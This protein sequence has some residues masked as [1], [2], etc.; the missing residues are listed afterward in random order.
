MLN[1]EYTVVTQ[2]LIDE[3]NHL[4]KQRTAPTVARNSP[5]IRLYVKHDGGLG[6]EVFYN[7]FYRLGD[8]FERQYQ[9]HM[10]A[11]NT[12]QT[13]HPVNMAI[14]ETRIL[15]RQYQHASGTPQNNL[16]HDVYEHFIRLFG[17]QVYSGESTLNHYRADDDDDRGIHTALINEI[18]PFQWCTF[19]AAGESAQE[20]KAQNPLC[21]F[22]REWRDFVSTLWRSFQLIDFSPIEPND[23]AS[24]IKNILCNQAYTNDEKLQAIKVL[25]NLTENDTVSD[26]ANCFKSAYWRLVYLEDVSLREEHF[27]NIVDTLPGLHAWLGGAMTPIDHAI[28]LGNKKD[29]MM[30]IQQYIAIFTICRQSSYPVEHPVNLGECCDASAHN[31]TDSRESVMHRI[32]HAIENHDNLQEVLFNVCLMYADISCQPSELVVFKQTVDHAFETFISRSAHSDGKKQHHLDEILFAYLDCDEGG[33]CTECW[34]SEEQL[35]AAHFQLYG[36]AAFNYRPLPYCVSLSHDT[37]VPTILSQNDPS[38]VAQAEQARIA[39]RRSTSQRRRSFPGAWRGEHIT[40]GRG[41][42]SENNASRKSNPNDSNEMPLFLKQDGLLQLALLIAN[43]SFGGL[44]FWVYIYKYG[45]K[46]GFIPQCFS[47][48]DR[49]F[50]A[51]LICNF[52]SMGILTLPFV[53]IV[54]LKVNESLSH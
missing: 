31:F 28:S 22:G 49:C 24:N 37:S 36:G 53:L 43:I 10:A 42:Q 47:Y 9:P 23:K 35:V 29:L 15:L 12:C 44:L 54:N 19:V 34:L 3:C 18:Y 8:G 46:D 50:V 41:A 14:N 21:S 38:V 1:R 17:A 13:F 20:K 33:A 52:F 25:A 51:L 6:I 11:T 30:L 27:D 7:H 40:K 39:A 4:L 26:E 45:G 16:L 48:P 32:Y 5:G 2:T